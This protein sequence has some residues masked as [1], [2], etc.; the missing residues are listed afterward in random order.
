M[1]DLHDALHTDQAPVGIN[2]PSGPLNRSLE[3]G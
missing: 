2:P 3:P 1:T